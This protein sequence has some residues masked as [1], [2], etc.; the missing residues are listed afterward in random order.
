MKYMSTNFKETKTQDVLFFMQLTS[1]S[2]GVLGPEN[3][4]VK[5]AHLGSVCNFRLIK[6]CKCSVH[7]S[8]KGVPG[9]IAFE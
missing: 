5:C 6:C 9:V 7:R 4:I 1:P 8:K 3:I 2:P